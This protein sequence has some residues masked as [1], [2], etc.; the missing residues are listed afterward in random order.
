VR[1]H[2]ADDGFVVGRVAL[3]EDPPEVLTAGE[4]ASLLRVDEAEL[5]K[6]AERDELPARRIAGEWRFSRTALPAWLGAA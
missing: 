6:A 1:E 2:L 4:A 5:L 3:R